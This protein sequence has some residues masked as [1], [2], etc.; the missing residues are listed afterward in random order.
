M[1][2]TG[3][4]TEPKALRHANVIETILFLEANQDVPHGAHR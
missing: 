2:T 3:I 4:A 1:K